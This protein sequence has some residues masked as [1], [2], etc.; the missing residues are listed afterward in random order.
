MFNEQFRLLVNAVKDATTQELLK[1]QKGKGVFAYEVVFD[2]LILKLDKYFYG[3][4]KYPCVN[5][6]V[7]NKDKTNIISETVRCKNAIAGEEFDF[8]EKLYST[9]ELKYAQLQNEEFSPLLAELTESL[10]HQLQA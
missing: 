2:N 3:D 7:F 5:F 6:T 10:Q 4:L 8:L 1:W 9:V